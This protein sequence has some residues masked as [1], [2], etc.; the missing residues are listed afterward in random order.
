MR[1][2]EIVEKIVYNVSKAILGKEREIY[3]IL[4]AIVAKGHILIEDVPGI[5]KTTLVKALAKSL[6]L[7]YKRIQFTTDLLPSDILG[8]SIYNDKQRDFEF[9]KGPIFS[10]IILADE[11]NR[12]SPKTQSALLEVMEEKQVTEGNE[13]Y[14]L[15]EPF[16][17]IATQNPIE[18]E[19]TFILPEA[20]LDRF[21]IK[22]NL[23]YPDRESEMNIL[24]I[25][26]EGNPLKVLESVVDREDIL[27]LQR[28]LKETKVNNAIIEYIVKIIEATRKN[29]YIEL[30]ASPRASLALI[31]ISQATAIIKGRYYVIPED[32]KENIIQVLAHRIRLSSKG[33]LEGITEKEVLSLI[34]NTIPLPKIKGD[35]S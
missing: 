32:V 31:K 4:K 14:K 5:G 8:I 18:F 24:K 7:Q 28:K 27:M 2:T 6:Q 21:I 19:G 11:I 23:G 33:R 22:I 34:I 3:D 13:T 30:G 1:E 25:Y 9:R 35:F 20:Q 12:T 29:P 10:N 17:V 26:S 16:I 15:Q